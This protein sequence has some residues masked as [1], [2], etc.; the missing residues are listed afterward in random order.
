MANLNKTKTL[1]AF[2]SPRTIEKII[3]EIDL[4]ISSFKGQLWNSKLQ[5]EYFKRLFNA[6]TDISYNSEES[7]TRDSL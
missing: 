2:T 1:F 4:L 7:L 5:T 6:G 3:P